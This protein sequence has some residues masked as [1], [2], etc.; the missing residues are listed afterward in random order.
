MKKSK[1]CVIVDDEPIAR[2][3][4]ANYIEQIPSLHLLKE[5]KDAFEAIDVLEEGNVDLLFLDINMPRLSGLSM[6][7]TLK[8]PP[9]VII[10]SAY[11][12]YALEGFELSV[13]DYLLK[14]FSFERFVQA[15]TKT[16]KASPV[17]EM[18]S[19][20]NKAPEYIFVK[21]DQKLIKVVIDEIRCIEAYGNYIKIHLAKSYILSKQTLSQFEEELPSQSFIRIH[22]SYIASLAHIDYAEGNQLAVA[23][24]FYPIGKMYKEALMKRLGSG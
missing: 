14:P 16:V 9:E 8:N 5:C 23:G 19:L 12:E 15:I 18:E 17:E 7:R 4:V 6:L 21:A 3:I 1:S 24:Q 13:V 20:N 10:T 11:A 22:K 2:A